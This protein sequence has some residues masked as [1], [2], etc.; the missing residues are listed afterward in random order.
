M[1]KKILIILG[2]LVVI[3]GCFYFYISMYDL[4]KGTDATILSPFDQ[5]KKIL[6]KEEKI[7]IRP[8][9]ILLLGIDRR[10]KSETSFRSDIMILMAIN[11]IAKKIVLISVPRDLWVGGGR[12]N[13]VYTQSGWEGMRSAFEKIT[14][15][16]PDNFILTDFSDF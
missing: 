9:N 15:Q 7:E 10:S 6:K 14:G 3:F 13:A 8:M 4:I 11:P 12:I 16:K 5:A 1:F 2:I